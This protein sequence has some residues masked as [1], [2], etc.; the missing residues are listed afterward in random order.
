MTAPAWLGLCFGCLQLCSEVR[1]LCLPC[2]NT[3]ELEGKKWR[4]CCPTMCPDAP[5]PSRTLLTSVPVA[6]ILVFVER[7]CVHMK[8]VHERK[9]KWFIFQN[10]KLMVF[11]KSPHLP[12][13]NTARMG[14]KGHTLHSLFPTLQTCED[15]L[16]SGQQGHWGSLPA[17][18]PTSLPG[19]S[20][21]SFYSGVSPRQVS[22]QRW[23]YPCWDLSE[24][25]RHC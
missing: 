11:D 21:S 14:K 10:A 16:D 1:Q 8:E 13:H 23:N 12:V 9:S 7:S 24:S 18:V 17:R 20:L 22:T 5:S 15:L 25:C 6:Y 19:D 3:A 4:P 2:V